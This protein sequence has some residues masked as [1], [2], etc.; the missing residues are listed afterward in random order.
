MFDRIPRRFFYVW[1]GRS[2]P[3]PNYLAVKSLRCVEPTAQIVVY[4]VGDRPRSWNFE[5]I[6]L[7][8]GVEIVHIEPNEIFER[9]PRELRRIGDVYRNI[10]NSAQSARSNILRY[11]LLLMHGGVYLDFDTIVVRRFGDL[12]E[13]PAFVGEEDVWCGD[14]S[15]V[16]GDVGVY[17]RPTTWHWALS[18]LG[19]RVDSRFFAG[20][21]GV[22]GAL[23]RTDGH[24]RRTQVNNAVI[25]ARPG[26]PFVREVLLAA[27]NASPTVRYATGP[28]LVDRVARTNPG[29]VHVADRS[30]FY[31]VA[32]GESFRLFEDVTIS[33][34][35][36][37][38]L[39]HYASSNHSSIVNRMSPERLDGLR[40]GSILG[41]LF[42]WVESAPLVRFPTSPAEALVA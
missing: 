33:L 24:W 21:L 7:L 26:S 1:S 31:H 30:T 38:N 20:R 6:E 16:R 22:A 39:I 3:Y 35:P 9:L 28:T 8:P 17:F 34:P 14:T 40:S 11:S 4:I 18:W 19:R 27:M 23:R 42:E 37:A 32:P 36:T 12:L 5:L 2:F 15:R 13:H 29:L 41:R 25:G 10:P